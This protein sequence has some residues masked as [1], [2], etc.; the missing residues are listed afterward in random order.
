MRYAHFLV[1]VAAL[2]APAGAAARPAQSSAQAVAKVKVTASEFKFVL[3][4]KSARRGVVTFTVT[5]VGKV[6]HDFSIH[7][8]HTRV[9]KHGQSETLRVGFLRKG[10][11][12]Y[13]CTVPGHAALGMNGI[14]T[15]T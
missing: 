13:K 8:R 2:V 6:G 10:H 9:L 12:A 7:G 15:I 11:Y 1:L 5:N 3:S 4:A 14:F